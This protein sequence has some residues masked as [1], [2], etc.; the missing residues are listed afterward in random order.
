MRVKRILVPLD[1]SPRAET[2]VPAAV[3]LLGSDGGA[4][5]ILLRA[6]D[7]KTPL[8]A[9]ATDAQVAAVREAQSYLAAVAERL[10]VDGITRVIRSVW[11]AA[12]AEAIVEAAQARHVDLIVMTAHGRGAP[13]RDRHGSVA[14]LVLRQARSPVLLV[15]AEGPVVGAAALVVPHA[16]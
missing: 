4:T 7:A 3:D 10:H 5:L 8:G 13:G 1:G 9:T 11:Y 14:E 16:R 12:P 2:A 15:S 6:V